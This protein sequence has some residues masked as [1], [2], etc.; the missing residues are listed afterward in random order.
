MANTHKPTA[1]MP[2]II[3][4]CYRK[5]ID[6]DSRKPW[7]QAVFNDTHLEFY[8]Q[9]Q[10]LDQEGRFKTFRELIDNVPDSQHLHY[11][12][13]TEA[14]G[15]IRQLNDI[16]PDI[17]NVSGKLCL[18]F[19]NFRFEILDSHTEQ[20]ERHKISIW[21]Y[22]DP[23]TWIDTIGD[24]LLI[25]YGDRTQA[26]DSGQ[27]VETDLIPLVP[28]LTISHYTQNNGQS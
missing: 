26:L 17:A 19:Q 27:E 3:R 23:V 14:I 20:K 5:I 11:L 12:T 16:V 2:R 18:P 28:Y 8:M 7:D 10:R 15:Y 13:S 1:K 24:K 4:L 9:A 6:I 22:S 21:F 25:A